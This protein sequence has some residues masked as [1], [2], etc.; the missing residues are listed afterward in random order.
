MKTCVREPLN[1]RKYLALLLSLAFFAR[2]LTAETNPPLHK[3]DKKSLEKSLIFPGWGQL[4]EKKYAKG[5]FFMAAEF[6]CIL[7]AISDNSQA[8]KYYNRYR[9]ATIPDEVV[10]F[11]NQTE[12]YDIRRNQY[13]L[14]G[15]AV[16]IVNLVDIYICVGKKSKERIRVSLK[17]E[18]NN[19]F[20][21]C[22]SY[23]F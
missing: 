18:K 8:E 23:H 15:A 21:F 4:N 3:E 9:N 11:R 19:G 5:V 20:I 14:A 13:L 22:L 1:S 7:Q 10:F 6:F 16:W 2:F 17:N 12:K